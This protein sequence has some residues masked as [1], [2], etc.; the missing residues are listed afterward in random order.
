MKKIIL[1]SFMVFLFS[2]KSDELK[3]K[4]ITNKKVEKIERFGYINNVYK[5]INSTYVAIDFIEYKKISEKDLANETTQTIDLPNGFSYINVK[6]EIEDFPF[7]KNVK[8]IMQTFS[9]NKEGNFNFN[10]IITLNELTDYFQKPEHERVMF[11]PFKIT[12]VDS[13]VSSLREIYIP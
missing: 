5:S 7:R 3:E 9:H 11:S 2:C 13:K 6:K 4:K 12:L 10:Q 1:I 8:I